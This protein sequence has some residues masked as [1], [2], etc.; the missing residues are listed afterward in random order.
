[1]VTHT[2]LSTRSPLR[3]PGGKFR[4]IKILDTF[5]PER[6]DTVLSP[7]VGGGSYE[8]HLT[9]L[10]AEVTAFDAFAPLV[11]FWQHLL[12]SPTKLARTA[13]AMRPLGQSQFKQFQNDLATKPKATVRDAAKYLV[14]NRSSFS[15]ATLSGGYSQSSE[16][17]RLTDTLID[18]VRGFRNDRITVQQG[19][20]TETLTEGYSLTFCDPPYLLEKQA[21]KLY[22]VGGSMHDSFDHEAFFTRIDAVSSPWLITYNDSPVLREMYADYEISSVCWSYGM[23]T[24]KKSSEIV[25]RNF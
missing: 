23:N 5:L 2:H 21:N 11:N 15:G 12:V 13:D 20:F 1:M 18:R 19:D 22:G 25:I 14:V 24:S 10:G 8:L 16:K 7:F 17:D 3:Y 9:S 4:A 6:I